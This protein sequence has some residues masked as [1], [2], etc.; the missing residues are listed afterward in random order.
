MNC[1]VVKLLVLEV[2]TI[3]DML[4]LNENDYFVNIFFYFYFHILTKK[5]IFLQEIRQI[6]KFILLI[7]K[8]LINHSTK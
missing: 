2:N 5:Y 1:L 6:V 8:V 3:K 7:G 4:L